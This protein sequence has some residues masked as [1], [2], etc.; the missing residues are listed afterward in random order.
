M[1]LGDSYQAKMLMFLL[2]CFPSLETLKIQNTHRKLLDPTDTQCWDREG[3]FDCV[4]HHLKLVTISR[5]FG[6]DSDLSFVRFLVLNSQML[7]KMILFCDFFLT[8]SI[9]EAIHNQLC[10]KDA[11]SSDVQVIFRGKVY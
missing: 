2:K 7:K 6:E 5:F 8:E 9:E 4:D 1:N 3:S 11:T 10:L